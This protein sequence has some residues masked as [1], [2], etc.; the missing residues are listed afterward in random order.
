MTFM[1]PRRI[2]SSAFA[3]A[4]GF[5]AMDAS[6]AD[7]LP[8]TVKPAAQGK[9]VARTEKSASTAKPTLR[10]WRRSAMQPCDS[11]A[12]RPIRFPWSPVAP[13]A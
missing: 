4:I 6:A 1:N 8:S 7:G 12:C 5:V 2:L 11:T 13:G 10:L 9:E 3:A